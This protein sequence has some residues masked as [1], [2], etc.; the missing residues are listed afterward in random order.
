MPYSFTEFLVTPEVEE[1][2]LRRFRGATLT[3][4]IIFSNMSKRH[5]RLDSIY[6]VLSRWSSALFENHWNFG[7]E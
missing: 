4:R 3:E 7:F 5:K 6:S 1:C 2:C